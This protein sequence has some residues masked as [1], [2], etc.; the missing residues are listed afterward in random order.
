MIASEAEGRVEALLR[1]AACWIAHAEELD[2][3]G[4]RLAALDGEL[5]TELC[6]AQ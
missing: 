3:G 2:L 6:H 4:L 5:L 1:I